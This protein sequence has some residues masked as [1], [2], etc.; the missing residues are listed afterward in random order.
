MKAALPTNESLRLAALHDLGILDTPAE[1][2]FDEITALAA[3]ICQTPIA[4]ITLVDESRQWFKSKIGLG[5]D[6]YARDSA[7]CAHALEGNELLIVPDALEDSR[8]SDN[9]LVLGDPYIR[10]YAGAPLVTETGETLGTLCVID[11]VPRQM[12][13]SQ[14]FALRVLSH[15]VLA[16]IRLS[17]EVGKS[18][19]RETALRASE[20]EQ[21]Q[22]ADELT[23]AQAVGHVGSWDFNAT[24]GIVTW[25]PEK[26][27]I[28]ETTPEKFT[29]SFEACLAFVHPDDREKYLEMHALSLTASK[30][31]SYQHRIILPDGK[32]KHL[33]ERWQ[34]FLNDDGSLA[35]A[36]GTCQ[37]ITERK[38]AEEERARLFNFTVDMLCVVTFEG[39]FLQVNPAWTTCLGW[40]TEELTGSNFMEFVHPEDL[41]IT[42]AALMEMH[43]GAS[44]QGFENRY[45][46]KDGSYRWFSWTAY[47]LDSTRQIFGSAR[48]ISRRR[49]VEEKLAR[50]NRLYQVLS[51]INETIVRV[52]DAQKLSEEVCRICTEQGQ[53]RMAAVFRCVPGGDLPDLLAYSGAEDGYFNE[54]KISLTSKELCQGTIGT[55][56]RTGHYDFCNDF[57]H[58]PRM[59][60]WRAPALRR[61]YLSTASFPIHLQG[62][63]YGLIVLFAAEPDYFQEDELKLLVSVAEDV[64]FAIES[65]HKEQLRKAAEAKLSEQATLLDKAQDAI[66]VR[67]LDNQILFWNQGAVRLYGW[68]AVEITGKALPEKMFLSSEAYHSAIQTTITDGEWIGELEQTHKD[69]QPLIVESRWTLIRDEL[70]S[71]KSILSINTDITERKKLEQQFLRAQRM[72]SIGTLAGGIAHD[73][74]NVLAP[75]M[76]SIDLLENYITAP[77]GHEILSMVGSSARRGADMVGQVLTFARGMDGVRIPVEI[78]S[79]ILDLANILR[80]T[81][82]KNCQ[83]QVDLQTEL[84]L[85]EADPTQLHQVILNLCVNARDAMPQGGTLTIR[86]HNTDIEPINASLNQDVDIGRYVCIEVEDTG[87][88]ISKETM[89]SCFDPFFTTK[90]VG[91]GTGLGLSTALAIVKSHGGF[92]QVY[93]DIGIGSRFLIYLPCTDLPPRE[94]AESR[95]TSLPRGCGET[96]LLVDDEDS[97]RQITQL[98]LETFGYT[99]LTAS[100]GADAVNMYIENRVAI[101]VVLTDMMMPIMDGSSLVKILKRIDPALC[102]IGASGISTSNL[103]ED[104]KQAGLS[105]FIPKPYT[106]EVLLTTLKEVL[107]ENFT[108]RPD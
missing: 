59:E 5:M 26:Y 72:E 15:Q 28:F 31:L 93:S 106:A 85:I 71:P 34:M 27:R 8:F 35:R 83:I 89:D 39:H 2:G 43:G 90:E 22:L 67:D 16:Q 50:L 32:M 51:R 19:R 69:G 54:V 29:P 68:T 33:E 88:G 78:Q 23:T 64:S 95:S 76:M 24:T 101:S 87:T 11:K 1:V 91:K 77:R 41:E 36:V 107:A 63:I 44:I 75:I 45:C 80:D 97:I 52:T 73:L 56:I 102:I 18:N 30:P 100:N 108:D 4:L 92:I 84:C 98:T 103:V 62:D 70:G 99:V 61:G 7:F 47:P 82:P 42:R 65:I 13:K 46:C 86:A 57:A 55:A 49:Q 10:F 53:F 48:D 104:A 12:S 96:V 94:L 66:I 58:D 81:F 38:L 17:S 40:S 21:R 60:P 79:L 25:S 37:D 74:N 3:E 9:P 105:R 6:E 14:L 20:R